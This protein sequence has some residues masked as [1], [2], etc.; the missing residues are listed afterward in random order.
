MSCNYGLYESFYPFITDTIVEASPD[1]ILRAM[2][3]SMRVF[4]VDTEFFKE[5]YTLDL[6]GGQT[7]YNLESIYDA[8]NYRVLTITVDDAAISN[9]QYT[10]SLSGRILTLTDEPSNDVT[11]GLVV[12]AV[13]RP[14][15]TCIE[16]DEDQMEVWAEAIISLTKMTLH[17]QPRKPWSDPVEAGYQKEEYEGYVELISQQNITQG[18]SG[19]TSVNFSA[20]V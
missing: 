15:L 5:E 7:V 20:R 8:K 1:D 4:A 11:D 18:Q 14:D 16:L 6:V 13:I 9:A 2:Q 3:M 12:N 19:A 17:A 10:L